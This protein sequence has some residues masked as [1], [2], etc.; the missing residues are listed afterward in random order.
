MKTKT[1]KK[2][3]SFLENGW[4]IHKGLAPTLTLLI[5]VGVTYITTA[6]NT[7]GVKV[8]AGASCQSE[9][10]KI[11]D[12]TDLQFAYGV[13][14]TNNTQFSEVF[15]MQ[16]GLEYSKKGMQQNENNAEL[17]NTFHYLTLPLLAEFSAGEK[18]GFKNG[19]QV[20]FAVGP[21]LSYL[22]DSKNELNGISTEIENDIRNYDI[23][24]RINLGFEF[25]SLNTHKLR[26]GLNYDMGFTDIYKTQADLQNKMCS[27][28]LGYVF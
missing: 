15:A 6:Q 13:G 19:K 8:L 25:P 4:K 10:L 22:I 11:S 5:M 28:S 9:L 7:W 26:V 21:Y 3:M 24:V 23:G 17:K 20:F 16:T 12:N 18:A 2:A 27:V 1:E 14:V